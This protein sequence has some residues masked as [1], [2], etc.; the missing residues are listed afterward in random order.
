M[1]APQTK[2]LSFE[3]FIEW[4]PEDSK[5]YE[6]IEGVVFKMLPTGSREDFIVKVY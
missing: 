4:Y 3:D 6:L 5:R 1:V 2:T